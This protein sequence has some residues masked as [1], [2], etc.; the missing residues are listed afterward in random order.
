MARYLLLHAFPLDGGMWDEVAG[1]LRG[2]GHDVAAPDL[3]GFGG[4]PLGDDQP[5]L[6]FLVS[7]AVTILD[8]V[9]AI[10]AGCSLGGYVAQGIARRRPDLVQALALVDTKATL[11]PP[12]A[13]DRREGVAVLAESGGE[14][15]AGMI[16]TLLGDTTRERS[17]AVVEYVEAALAA[18]PLATVAWMQRAMAARPD[19]R[20]AL[21]AL[22]APVLAIVGEEDVVSPLE[23]QRIILDLV[24]DGR[25]VTVPGA[26]HLTPLE[27]PGTV[28]E[29]L[30][31]LSQA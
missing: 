30:R 26:G 20:E 1:R 27:A 21:G 22:D 6:E 16:D 14:W 8:D 7:D 25:L 5:D 23:E 4:A 19:G 13:R 18:A 28:A 24:R 2:A 17:P 9:P 29:A 12:A 10:I 15:S 11:D 3:R 31:G